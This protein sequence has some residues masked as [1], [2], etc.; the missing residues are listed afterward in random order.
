MTA[1]RKRQT[2][3][4]ILESAARL[5]CERG[6]ARASVHEVM[7]GAGLTV[8]GFYAHFDSKEALFEETFRR[9]AEQAWNELVEDPT[10]E[11]LLQFV[12][13]YLS[14][15]H[16]D[17]PAEGCPLP[18]TVGDIE[19]DSSLRGVLSEQLGRFAEAT[20]PALGGSDRSLALLALLFGGLSLARALGADDPL[21]QQ[22]LAGCRRF[23]KDTLNLE[24]P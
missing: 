11:R 19:E 14:R 3:E 1:H 16:R 13:R 2:R 8:G 7:S 23:A 6:P 5:L 12:R 20:G 15:T 18:S 10:R 17:H 21:S 24:E 9:L 22:M 4:A